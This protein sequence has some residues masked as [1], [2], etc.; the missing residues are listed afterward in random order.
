LNTITAESPS[1]LKKQK[2]LFP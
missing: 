2:I 1:K